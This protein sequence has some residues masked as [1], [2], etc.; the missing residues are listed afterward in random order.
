LTNG[1]SSGILFLMYQVISLPLS[2]NRVILNTID[3]CI[4]K[5]WSLRIVTTDIVLVIIMVQI[6]IYII[7][8]FSYNNLDILYGIMI[9]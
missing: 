7:N 5:I 9:I 1:Y 8:Y 2:N 6:A 3:V 4:D